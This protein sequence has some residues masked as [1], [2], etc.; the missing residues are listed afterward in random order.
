MFFLF[1]LFENERY[2]YF[3]QAPPI[4]GIAELCFVRINQ[5][6]QNFSFN[7]YNHQLFHFIT[8]I[9]MC[10][11]ESGWAG[12]LFH[13]LFCRKFTGWVKGKVRDQLYLDTNL[14][15]Q[16]CEETEGFVWIAWRSAK[17]ANRFISLS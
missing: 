6:L 8:Y 1:T 3:R 12:E 14:Q 7:F 5:I 15:S 13:V 2:I 10:E 9:V 4:K 16:R 17:E 11:R